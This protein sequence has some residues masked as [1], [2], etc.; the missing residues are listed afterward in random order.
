VFITIKCKKCGWAVKQKDVGLGIATNRAGTWLTIT[1][2]CNLCNVSAVYY[3]R[4]D[5]RR[6][7]PCRKK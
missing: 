5:Q 1:A 2:Y 4:E 3:F 6:E 7:D